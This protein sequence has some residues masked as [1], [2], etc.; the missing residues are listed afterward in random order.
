MIGSADCNFYKN[1]E[2]N[3]CFKDIK[4]DFTGTLSGVYANLGDYV[5][6]PQTI[7]DR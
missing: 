3:E 2:M 5:F 7:I 6:T 4:G 1:N